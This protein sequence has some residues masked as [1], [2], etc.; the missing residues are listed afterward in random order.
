M[1][2]LHV[3]E[4]TN[5]IITTNVYSPPDGG[6]TDGEFC[7]HRMI[8][9]PVEP[10][11]IDG[12]PGIDPDLFFDDDGT[13]GTSEITILDDASYPGGNWLQLDPVS[14]LVES[15]IFCGAAP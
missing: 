5:F 4:T 13:V 3:V 9:H 11:V 8:Q 15:V 2:R 14:S 12:V 6:D 10:H 7:P 1:R